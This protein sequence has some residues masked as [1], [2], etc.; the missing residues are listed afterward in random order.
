MF[1]PDLNILPAPQRALWG[2]LS[3]T[4][5]D[6]VL[7]GGT[8][9]ALRL[10]HRQSEDFD[11]F[12]NQP[13]TP[14]KLRDA[15]SYLKHAEMVQFRDNTLTAIL[16]R[17]GPVRVSFFGALSL[18]RIYDPDVVEENQLQVASL[19]DLAGTKLATIQQ[20]AF[21]KDYLDVAAILGA[22]I[23][24]ASGLA[25]ARA[26]YGKE[27]NGALSLKALVYFADG[28]LP[29]LGISIQNHLRTAALGVKFGEPPLTP[30]MKA[31]PGVTARVREKAS[32]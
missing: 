3:A 22:G 14:T 19:M 10:G 32:C 30:L 31:R 20:R 6:F 17:H 13:F 24:L 26:I 1:K 25:A 7:Y 18:G 28:D 29:S 23:D 12:S 27:F 15:V 8:A 5:E 21:A 2:E 16:D 9:M 4:P 11:F